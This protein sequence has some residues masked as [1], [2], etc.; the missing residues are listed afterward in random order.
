MFIWNSSKIYVWYVMEFEANLIPI[1]TF[2]D[3]SCQKIY[4]ERLEMSELSLPEHYWPKIA[5]LL[6]IKSPFQRM[7][8]R[9]MEAVNYGQFRLLNPSVNEQIFMISHLIA[10]VA[11]NAHCNNTF[12]SI[13]SILC[14]LVA[15]V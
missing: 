8:L 6:V 3:L 9:R 2:I 7:Y 11:V 14:L 15:H 4:C 1:D 13:F 5:L 12:Y 10:T